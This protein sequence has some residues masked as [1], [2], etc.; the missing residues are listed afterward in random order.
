VDVRLSKLIM[1]LLEKS[2]D[3]R[4]QTSREVLASLEALQ[5]A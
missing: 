4:P 1:A 2:P 5:A 3:G